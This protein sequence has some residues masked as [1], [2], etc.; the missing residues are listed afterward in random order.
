MWPQGLGAI[1]INNYWMSPETTGVNRLPMLN[2]EHLEKI[3]LDGIWRFQ[4][5]ESPTDS[6]RK[7]W[8]K[9]QVPGLWTMQPQSDTFFDKPIYTNVQMPFGEN[10]PT[11]PAQNPTGIYERDFEIPS[12]WNGKRIILHLG[13]YES[14]ALIHV[15]NKEI[16]L[17]KDS[18]LAAEFDITPFLERGKNT[19]R[20]TVVKWSD[21]TFIEDQDHWW[22][23]GISRS[24]KLYATNK[25]YIDRLYTT[26]GIEKDNSTG[27]LKIEAH[28]ASDEVGDLHG[29][30]LR[31]YIKELPKVSAANLSKTLE[32]KISPNWT[33]LSEKARN[34]EIEK[35]KSWDGTVSKSSAAALAEIRH[36]VRGKVLL[37]S[38]IAKINLWSAETPNLYKLNFELISPEGT[39]LQIGSQ[40]IGFR[41]VRVVGN[42][43]LVNGQAITIYGVN[44]HDFNRHTGR[45]LTRDDMREDLL[46]MKCWNFN[47]VRTSHYPNDP[48]FLDLTDELGFYVIDEANIESHAFYD[49]MCE[50][51]RYTGAF[52]ERVGRMV[53]RDIHHPSVILWSLGNE[54]GFGA[55]HRAAA[56]YARSIDPSRPLHYEGA[57]NGDWRKGVGVTDIVCPMYPSLSA[58]MSYVKSGKQDR[59]FIMCEYSHAMGNSNGTLAEYWEFI[60]KTPGAQ[61]GFIWEFWDHGLDQRLPDGSIHAAY[62]GDFGEKIHDGNFVC[63]GMVFP[64]RTAKPAMHEMKSL[65]APAVITAKS[66]STGKFEIF[67]KQFFSDLSAFEIRWAI[68]CDGIVLDE[69]VA[70]IPSVAPRKKAV[71]SIKSGHL[72][73]AAEKGER[74]ITFTLHAK[75]STAWAS[76]MAEIGWSQISLTSRA[77]D[78]PNFSPSD[79]FDGVID[80]YAEIQLPYSVVAPKLSLWRAPTDND[81]IG[82]ISTKWERWG[83]RE[84]T[85]EECSV[86]ESS[87]KLTIKSTWKT[88][89]GFAVKH[90]QV[91][92]PIENGFTVN[93]SVD[94]PKELNDVARVGTNFELSGGLTD[95]TWFGNGPHESYPDRKIGRISR[96]NSSIDNQYIPYV[97][98]QE[99]GGHN[100]M[101]WFQITDPTGTGLRID[102][103]KPYQV[104][105]TPNRGE[106][107]A[108]ATHD[109]QVNACGNVVVHIDAAH[110]G[111][112]TASCGPDT[113]DKYLISTGTHSWQWSVTTLS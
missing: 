78:K 48:A 14:V 68:T 98:P 17:T 27:T 66:T 40:K 72:T 30:T 97:R 4:L 25:V 2:I 105:V 47:A 18:H 79:E 106:D 112:G 113:L 15:N 64:D 110:R 86:T 95:L 82:H 90:I 58:V 80:E 19:V 101:R 9:I 70:K 24:V 100:G 89:T 28:I 37:E 31:A 63:D 16:G 39:V 107:L 54:S 26:A 46:E 13:G 59:P 56:T 109:Y 87:N 7:K 44:R 92:T 52:V 22:H 10:P 21:A 3:S 35:R 84:L 55:N 43:L 73:K 102:L 71:F 65:A 94:L 93:E 20:I 36:E 50:D 88:S 32:T 45:V 34:A 53:Q 99:N 6:S 85:R 57:I 42:D 96:W 38:R 62:G 75:L 1:M 49:S 76:A 111:L 23:G 83:L 12:S 29:Y 74:F 61:G 104:S 103:A 33:E 91:I 8:S 81:R 67:N 108:D 51:P 5:L 11:V 69:G 77:L 60:E 41:D